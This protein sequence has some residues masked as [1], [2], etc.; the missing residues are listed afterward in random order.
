MSL[1]TEVF[2]TDAE[3][4]RS[5]PVPRRR[6]LKTP[7]EQDE[8]KMVIKKIAR[9]A[10][11]N[12]FTSETLKKKQIYNTILE[13]LTMLEDFLD[14]YEL[15]QNFLITM[16]IYVERYIKEVGKQAD[17]SY[18]NDIFLVA[19]MITVKMWEDK[20]ITNKAFSKMFSA[21]VKSLSTN[22]IQFLA[23]IDYDLGVEN[24]HIVDF[25][26]RLYGLKKS[27]RFNLALTS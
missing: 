8:M 27:V 13:S 15:R 12:W 9:Y 24:S 2:A 19:T 3:L 1:L 10:A 21:N 18:A 22:E 26:E 5:D 17:A 16:V 20:W 25:M 14:Y 23:A 4:S 7:E 11:L 6:L